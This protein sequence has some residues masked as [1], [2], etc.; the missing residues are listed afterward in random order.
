MNALKRE[1]VELDLVETEWTEAEETTDGEVGTGSEIDLLGQYLKETHRY[2]LLNRKTEQ[3]V[4]RAMREA[5]SLLSHSNWHEARWCWSFSRD[6]AEGPIERNSC[7]CSRTTKHSR[8][9]VRK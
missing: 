3:E 6:V 7:S 1:E 9:L 8:A 5:E 4:S 2:P